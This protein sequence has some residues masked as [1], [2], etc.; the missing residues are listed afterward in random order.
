MT[1]VR[2]ATIA[3]PR[4]GEPLVSVVIS[5]FNYERFLAEAIGSALDQD[6]PRT[7][8]IVVDDGSTDRSREVIGEFGDRVTSVFKDN[9]GQASALNAGFRWS[10]GDCVIFL[11]SDD[12]L[13]PGAAG[14]AARALAAGQAVKAH[15]SMPVIDGNGRRTGAIQD[16]ELTEGDLRAHAL[17]EG[18]LSDMT[19]P[20]PPMSG[21]AFA[22]AF[23]ER[24]MPIP[25]EHYRTRPDEYLFGLA[26]SF[27]PIARLSHQSLYRMHGANA[28]HEQSF[29]WML[30][31]QQ[32]HHAIVAE[33]AAQAFRREQLS[34]DERLWAQSSWW[35]RA[36]R[37]AR[38][39]EQAV[40]DGERVA[41]IDQGAL[42][43]D[44][45]LRGRQVLAFPRVDGCFAGAPADDRAAV[46]ELE[47][48]AASGV[49]HFVLAWPAFWWLEEY[50]GLA[51]R[52]RSRAILAHDQDLL[53][54][55]PPREL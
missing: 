5:S 53:V 51:A 27:G 20:S 32:R 22:R 7:E 17:A 39:I 23:L 25:E 3:T 29:E 42:G 52:L 54:F 8:V 40:P 26:P 16:R 46:R 19:M 12:M 44:A 9:G 49:S 13:L 34:Y 48:I 36:G 33:V 10:H 18:P 4:G 47:R 24:V 55:G 37:V 45:Q 28:H 2:C 15:W 6:E 38:A 41:L 43:I 35:L 1:R 31:F 30:A 14:A 11:D 21:N 50:P